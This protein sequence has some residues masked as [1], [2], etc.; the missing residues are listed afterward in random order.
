VNADGT[1]VRRVTPWKL[2][3]GDEL[4]DFLWRHHGA[5]FAPFKPKALLCRA[6]GNSGAGFEPASFGL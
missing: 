2:R 6:F 5:P 3:A 4:A 1:G